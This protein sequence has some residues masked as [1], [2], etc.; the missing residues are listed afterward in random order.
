MRGAVLLRHNS[1]SCRRGYGGSSLLK[2]LKARSKVCLRSH[3]DVERR[4]HLDV[5]I[6][7][8]LLDQMLVLSPRAVDEPLKQTGR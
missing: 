7:A 6:E 3:C 8:M 2:R 1:L 4:R 5:K